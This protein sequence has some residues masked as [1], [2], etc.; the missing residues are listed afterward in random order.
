MGGHKYS[1]YRSHERD[2]KVVNKVASTRNSTV[3]TASR[4]RSQSQIEECVAARQGT[5]VSNHNAPSKCDAHGDVSIHK[6][7]KKCLQIGML[8]KSYAPLNKTPAVRHSEMWKKHSSRLESCTKRSLLNTERSSAPSTSSSNVTKVSVNRGACKYN[9]SRNVNSTKLGQHDIYV[10][11][12]P[13]DV[14]SNTME[15]TGVAAQLVHAAVSDIEPLPSADVA[16]VATHTSP[17]S[18]DVPLNVKNLPAHATA[19]AA[20]H[21]DAN[22]TLPDT[23]DKKSTPTCEAGNAAP[24]QDDLSYSENCSYTT[25]GECHTAESRD[26]DYT[27]SPSIEGSVRVPYNCYD[28][29]GAD[30]ASQQQKSQEQMMW[31][32]GKT[33]RVT[34]VSWNMRRCKPNIKQLSESCILP[35]AHIIVVATQENGPYL[36]TNAWQ[37]RWEHNVTVDCLNRQFTLVGKE[38][39]WAVHIAVYARTRDVLQYVDHVHHSR[40]PVGS[41]GIGAFLGNKGG[42]AVGLTVSMKTRNP[43]DTVRVPGATTHLNS[44][45]TAS[46][47]LSNDVAFKAE[48][49]HTHNDVTSGHAEAAAAGVVRAGNKSS[50]CCVEATAHDC[51]RHCPTDGGA[52]PGEG[53]A[54]T[55]SASSC[56]DAETRPGLV[57]VSELPKAKSAVNEVSAALE[58]APKWSINPLSPYA[59]NDASD[60]VAG[61]TAGASAPQTVQKVSLLDSPP[62]PSHHATQHAVPEKCAQADSDHSPNDVA[63]SREFV[64]FLFINAHLPAY[65]HGIKQRNR[66]Y[67]RIVCGLRVGVRG[68]HS[69][70]FERVI[71]TSLKCRASNG[72]SDNE[73]STSP[74]ENSNTVNCPSEHINTS[75]CQASMF[76]WWGHLWR[77]KPDSA[78]DVSQSAQHDHMN[79]TN[80][81]KPSGNK[82]A[83]CYSKISTVTDMLSRN[84]VDPIDVNAL[85]PHPFTPSL[86]FSMFR[87][88]RK[89]GVRTDKLMQYQR[90]LYVVS[91]DV[92]EQ[93]DFTIFGGDLNYRINGKRS[94]IESNVQR[95]PRVRDSLLRNDQLVLEQSKN[96]VFHRF[97]EGKMMFQPTYKYQISHESADGGNVSYYSLKDKKPPAYCDRILYK[98][99][100]RS[101]V[102]KVAIRLYTDVPQI[103]ASD[104]R[105]VVGI[106]EIETSKYT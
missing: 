93:F 101:N 103:R 31:Y 4:T 86:G 24:H 106:Y 15:L 74:N 105:P 90:N 21:C 67:K 9:S 35:N 94:A 48:H 41:C 88:T 95:H 16:T 6:A 64:T 25:S 2:G 20:G 63:A 76:N 19:D 27:T 26:V 104:H 61:E 70:L 1:V 12:A 81:I 5:A 10:S 62:T 77:R 75:S 58:C 99:R 29:T 37:K 54:N 60:P 66:S 38:Q 72:R 78:C 68:S 96:L 49:S 7:G 28:D 100:L 34:Y 45:N 52:A 97:K 23:V 36:G 32:P 51:R 82:K 56:P 46:S 102:K 13:A 11:T 92:T 57:K 85:A 83:A 84:R 18:R 17:S 65:R 39:L 50:L 8:R 98:K 44:T 47:S 55:Y 22:H 87:K 43:C 59:G 71:A 3:N 53:H 42:V 33:L 73:A 91:K 30:G 14:T 89:D 80:G 69:E 40:V 79:G